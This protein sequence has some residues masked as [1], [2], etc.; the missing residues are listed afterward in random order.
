[1][2]QDALAQE[3]NPGTSDWI[4]YQDIKIARQTCLGE[5]FFFN[6][7]LPLYGAHSMYQNKE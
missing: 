5:H 7:L 4:W 6:Q 3:S 2:R 1:M